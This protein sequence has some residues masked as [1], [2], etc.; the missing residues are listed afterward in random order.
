MHIP[1]GFLDPVVA[2][3]LYILSIAVV[4]YS[5]R[6]YFSRGGDIHYLSVTAAAIFAAQMLN[7]PI[8]GGTSAHFV[9]GAFASI[10]LGPFGGCLAMFMNLVVQCLLMGDGGITALG[11][12]NFNMAVVGVF[13]GYAIY[14][15]TLRYLGEGKRFLSAFLAGW[16]SITLAAVT[17]G[18]ELGLSPS[19]G[20][21]I[22][23]TVP[24]MG[25]WHLALGLVEGLATA[26]IITYLSSRG[27]RL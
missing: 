1:D 26:L 25:V 11:A 3:T 17:C 15:A 23:I 19:F 16:M 22:A 12:N 2:L 4:I 18:V 10:L 27:L 21:P 20:Y 5:G 8:P 6:R 9:G 14:K 7:W 24:V 13:A